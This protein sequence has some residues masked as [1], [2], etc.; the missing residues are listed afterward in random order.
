MSAITCIFFRDDRSVDSELIIKMNNQLSHRGPDG[1]D[2]WVEE[3]VGLGHQMLWTTPESLHENL[4]LEKN[5]LIITADARIDNRKDLSRQLGIEDKL[6]VSD[7]DFI[8][9]AY[10]KW[11]EKCPEFLLGDF[12]FVI[13]DKKNDKLFCARDHMGIK[14]FYYYVSDDNFFIATE[15]K[16]LLIIPGVPKELNKKKLALFLMRD[17]Q[18]NEYTFYKKIKSLPAAH[19]LKI[20]KNHFTIN[21]FWELDSKLQIEMDSEEEYV[22]AFRKIFNEAVKCR[23]RSYLPIG[24]ELSGGL[25]SSSVVCMAKNILEKEENI[26]FKSITTF[27]RV[28]DKIPECDER[29]FIQK[30]LDNGNIKSNFLL[31]DNISPLKN[32][33]NILWHQDQPFFSPHMTNQINTYQKISD[34]GIRILLSGEGGDEIVSHGGNYIRELFFSF[35]LKKFLEEIKGSSK[36]LDQNKTKIFIKEVVFPSI[37]YSFKKFIKLISNRNTNSIINDNFLESAGVEEV[38]INHIINHIGKIKTKDYHYF[39]INNPLSQTIFGITDRSSSIYNIEERYPFYDIRLIEFCYSLPTEMKLKFGWDRY[40]MRI[41]MQDILPP[42]IQ[43]R[44]QKS[45][46][47]NIYK[48]NLILFEKDILEKIVYDDN[49]VIKNYVNLDEIQAIYNKYESGKTENLFNFW[50]VVSIYLWIKFSEIDKV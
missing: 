8:L 42:E 12:A 10:E 35:K 32:I 4:P 37:P 5:G 13:W 34:A 33:N 48:R 36:K 39:S 49:K 20:D 25:D 46:L 19:F 18:D 41:A 17:I 40:I 11:G 21:K 22:K 6:D 31:G 24:F 14:Q 9:K 2:I 30:V 16:A 44:S 23:L 15:I 50:L 45:N 47:S 43:W 7:S 27:S 38:D 26:K 1:N 28:Y 3:N 29:F